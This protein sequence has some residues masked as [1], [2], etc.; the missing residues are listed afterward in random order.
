MRGVY[1]LGAVQNSAYCELLSDT[2]YDDPKLMRKFPGAIYY[3]YV[4]K[5]RASSVA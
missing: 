3:E 1:C 5:S 4:S 2:Q